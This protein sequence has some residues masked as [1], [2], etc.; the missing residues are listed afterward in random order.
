[1]QN[2]IFL[3]IFLLVGALDPPIENRP[4]KKEPSS[5]QDTVG[6]LVYL[7]NFEHRCSDVFYID[8]ERMRVVTGK[9]NETARPDEKMLQEQY[10]EEIKFQNKFMEDHHIGRMQWCHLQKFVLGAQG[11][12]NFF[13]QNESKL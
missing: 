11:Y 2:I 12:D 10:V 1:M 5:M 8:K 4:L 13:A 7:I 9:L 3:S 6:L